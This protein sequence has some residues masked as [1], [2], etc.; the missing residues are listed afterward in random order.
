MNILLD[1]NA[2]NS[3]KFAEDKK[4]A[5]YLFNQKVNSM[6]QFRDFDD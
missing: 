3:R 2:N 4:H 1:D 5:E 6:H